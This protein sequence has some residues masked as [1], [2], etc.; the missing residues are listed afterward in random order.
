M[1]LSG[2]RGKKQTQ[3]FFPR[4]TKKRSS[5]GFFCVFPEVYF[6]GKVRF[7][8]NME[9]TQL[10]YHKCPKCNIRHQLTHT[11]QLWPLLMSLHIYHPTTIVHC[12]VHRY[13]LLLQNSHFVQNVTAKPS[14]SF[15]GFPIFLFNVLLSWQCGGHWH[16]VSHASV[17]YREQ[18][19]NIWVHVDNSM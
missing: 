14:T 12:R 6:K 2:R 16:S 3:F 18:Q 4:K 10:L 8:Q 11:H 9:L 7:T 15:L 1:A 17:E 19:V 13:T 5:V